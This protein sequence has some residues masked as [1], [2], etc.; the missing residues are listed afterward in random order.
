MASA[1]SNSGTRLLLLFLLAWAGPAH[2]GPSEDE[3]AFAAQYERA[4]KLYAAKDYAAAIPALQAAFAIRPV[5][6]LLYNIAQ[7]YRRLEQWTPARVYFEMYRALARDEA[8]ETL[9]NVDRNILE[10]R[11]REQAEQKPELIEKT[12]IIQEEKPPPRWLRPAGLVGSLAGIGLAISGGVFLGIDGQ[13]TGAVDPPITQCPQIYNT[14]TPGT[15]LTAVGAGLF[16]ASAVIF[17][18]SLK[19]PARPVKRTETPRP[20]PPRLK[21]PALPIEVE[22][23]PAGFIKTE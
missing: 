21:L 4:G 8:S 19:K 22:P 7:S 12:L 23:P 9:T 18:L 11:E 1:R 14:K 13:C 2:A 10:M 6:Q 16:V 15:A 17:G 3:G 5:P 20:S